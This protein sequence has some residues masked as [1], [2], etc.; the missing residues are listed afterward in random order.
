MQILKIWH[1][2]TTF[3]NEKDQLSPTFWITATLHASIQD[4]DRGHR[5]QRGMRAVPR[6]INLIGMTSQTETGI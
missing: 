1:K 4:E 5:S 2:K 6:D 3:K